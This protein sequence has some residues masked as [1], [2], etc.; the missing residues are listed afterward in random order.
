MMRVAIRRVLLTIRYIRNAL[1][2]E[3]GSGGLLLEDGS[4]V[5]G[6]E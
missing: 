2:L 4:D 3:D 1:M 6:L 5:L